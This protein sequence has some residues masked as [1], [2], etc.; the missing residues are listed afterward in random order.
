MSGRDPVRMIQGLA[1]ADVT[2]ATPRRGVYTAFLTAKG[3]MVAVAR[4]FV[5]AGDGPPLLL[6]VDAAAG[7]ALLEH[8]GRFVPP[9]FGK[10]KDVSE[11]WAVVG[12]YGPGSGRVVAA[13]ATELLAGPPSDAHVLERGAAAAEETVVQ[14]EVAEGSFAAR[15]ELTGDE[16]WDLFLPTYS[17]DAM[18][19]A[20]LAAGARPGAP[21]T[22]EALRVSAGRPRWGMELTDQVIPL[23]AGL[24]E[25]AIS[26]SKGCYTGQEV[27][28]RILHRGHVN[29]HLRRLVFEAGAPEAGTELFE[30][31]V[32]RARGVVTSAVENDAGALGLGYVRRE[33]DPPADLRVGSPDGP[34]VRV[35]ALD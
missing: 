28:V 35:E 22:L 3:R 4:V 5:P 33:V 11:S 20:L 34:G 15:T 12:V 2:S 21:E 14:L 26:Q 32:E 9:L 7:D 1:T 8:I 17:R 29:R 23:E 13:A 31:G 19:T 6:D 16:G 18:V 25:R 24:L 30:P 10:A 27:I